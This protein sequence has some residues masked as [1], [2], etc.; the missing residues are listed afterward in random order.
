METMYDKYHK[1]DNIEEVY[2][3]RI[4]NELATKIN[5]KIKPMQIDREYQLYYLPEQK[6]A[7][8]LAKIYKNDKRLNELNAELPVIARKSFIKDT[9]IEE[10]YRTNK[11]EGV[12]SS[13]KELYQSMSVGKENKKKVR[14][15]SLINSYDNLL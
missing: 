5:L 6:H 9:L 13:R 15:S 1:V 12:R 4:N 10:L 7:E 3:N 2:K 14:F 8:Q 11:I